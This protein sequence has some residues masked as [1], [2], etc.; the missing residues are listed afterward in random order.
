MTHYKEIFHTTFDWPTDLT[1]QQRL[2]APEDY[3]EEN[4][5]NRLIIYNRHIGGR[6]IEL[7]NDFFFCLL[8][9]F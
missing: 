5:V 8:I 4:L 6:L 2:I 9:F 7:Q 1:V 3:T